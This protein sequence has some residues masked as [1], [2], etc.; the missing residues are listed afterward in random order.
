MFASAHPE[1]LSALVLMNTLPAFDHPPQVSGTEEQMAAFGKMFSQPMTSDQEFRDVW[2]QVVQMYFRDYDPETGDDID[3]R[4]NYS[5]MAW[6]AAGP[7]LSDFN[8]LETLPM[9]DVPTLVI[10][11]AHDP[12]TPVE[13]GGD[14]IS[15]L[16]PDATGI[17]YEASGHFPFIEQ[18]STVLSDLTDWISGLE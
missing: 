13:H 7:M 16:I 3:A 5:H 15:S 4:T 11:G 8:T 12:I 2:T 1:K 6:N 9:I 10:S 17:T 18:E 14:R